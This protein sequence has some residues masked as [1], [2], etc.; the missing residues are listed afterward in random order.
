MVRLKTHHISDSSE[1]AVLN[2]F[3]RSVR[4]AAALR[5]IVSTLLTSEA[6]AL[7]MPQP[8]ARCRDP[9][10]RKSFIRLH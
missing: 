3:I 2:S 7:P 6:V 1:V 9:L 10:L 5:E 8:R 4:A